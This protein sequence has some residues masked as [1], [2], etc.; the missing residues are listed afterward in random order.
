VDARLEW[1]GDAETARQHKTVTWVVRD[2]YLSL[3]A[4][5]ADPNVAATALPL[6][7]VNALK[8]RLSVPFEGAGSLW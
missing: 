7:L 4:N 6:L 2:R 3:K 5:L 1:V 8:L